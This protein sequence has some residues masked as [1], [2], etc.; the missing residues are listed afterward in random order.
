MA[1]YD[2]KFHLLITNVANKTFPIRKLTLTIMLSKFKKLFTKNEEGFTLVE[3]MIVVVIIGILAAIAIPVF[4]NQQKGAFD[5][6]A[7]S[8]LKQIS[9]A[10][11]LAKVKTK[12][13]LMSI[14]GSN[15]TAGSC[16]YLPAG[17]DYAQLPKT[18]GC[19]STYF[20]ALAKISTASGMNVNNLLDPYDRPYYLDENEGEG[21]GCGKDV[22]GFYIY[23]NNATNAGVNA[24]TSYKVFVANQTPACS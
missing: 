19:W 6:H 12:L 11:V 2:K 13:P 4:A 23:P 18:N 16:A 24:Q 15:F 20:S 3:L 22:V 10:I 17:T 5:A 21:G 8:D 1:C 7:K 14:T 9:E